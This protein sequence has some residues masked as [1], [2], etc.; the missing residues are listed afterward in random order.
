MISYQFPIRTVLCLLLPLF[1]TGSIAMAHTDQA[2]LKVG[3][4]DGG[5]SSLQFDGKELLHP[6]PIELTK[7]TLRHGYPPVPIA[8]PGEPR[9]S[10][11]PVQHRLRQTYPWGT[12]SCVYRTENDRL[13]MDLEIRNTSKDSI[14]AFSARL[15][16]MQFP[17]PVKT[18]GWAH[19]WPTPSVLTDAPQ[20]VNATWNQGT[21][22]LCNE[23]VD[24][25]LWLNLSANEGNRYDVVCRYEGPPRGAEISAGDWRQFTLSL[26][27]G[28]QG[29]D[30]LALTSDLSKRF[31][32]QFPFELKWKDHRPIGCAFLSTTDTKWKTNPRGWFQD[33]TI[34][35]TTDAGRADFQ[36]RVLKYAD[37]CVRIAKEMDAQGV[38][39][40]DIEGQENPHSISYIG[41]P[42]L[43][44]TLAPEIDPVAD[45][46]FK[47]IT[48]AGLRAGV[49][50]RP[51]HVVRVPSGKNAWTHRDTENIVEELAGKLEY[52]RK[53]W[54]CTL[55]YVDSTVRWDLTGDGEF[56][57]HTL[58]ADYMQ[59]LAR[60]FPDVLLIPEQSSTRHFAYSAPYHEIMQGF[61]ATPPEVRAVYPDSFTALRVAELPLIEKNFDALV[62]AVQGGD[63]LLYRT[64]FDDPENE[65]IKRILQK[66]REKK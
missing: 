27:F 63:I 54:G 60:R 9:I 46:F 57:L 62:K 58:P 53:R 33:R 4:G 41:D 45:A 17:S 30:P 65:P 11:D 29:A 50:I 1:C 2:G 49:T 55:F 48:D 16:Q 47:K 23:Q 20:V 42:R 66:A 26:R 56:T 43:T 3:F 13:L 52:A 32:E 59:T 51:T 7:L 5:L 39:V 18:K 21:L 28:P 37:T 10:F 22:A 44:A 19:G 24:L 35:I 6:G 36:Q 12:L 8:M 61:T 14:F 38:I 64:W 31:A 15:L 25:P 40:W 34:D